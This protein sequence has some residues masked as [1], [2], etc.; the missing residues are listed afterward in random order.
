MTLN[1]FYLTLSSPADK[2]KEHVMV[3]NCSDTLEELSYPRALVLSHTF[4]T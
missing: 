4:Q 2:P 3:G 1:V